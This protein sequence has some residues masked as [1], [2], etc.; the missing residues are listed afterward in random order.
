MYGC[1]HESALLL[2]L[3]SFVECRTHLTTSTK[4]ASHIEICNQSKSATPCTPNILPCNTTTCTYSAV[5]NILH[6]RAVSYGCRCGLCRVN[7][8]GSNPK[9]S[10][11]SSEGCVTFS[12]ISA[13]IHPIIR[14]MG[15][16]LGRMPKAIESWATISFAC[17]S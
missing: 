12:L 7:G 1:M 17:C 13:T 10:C 9:K 4:H 16:L 3:Q 2:E 11:A 15:E 5:Q 6:A 8:A 14:V